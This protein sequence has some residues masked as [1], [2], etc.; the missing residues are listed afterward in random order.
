KPISSRLES[1]ETVGKATSSARISFV[2]SS[3]G[4]LIDRAASVLDQ[5]LARISAQAFGRTILL[6][7]DAFGDFEAPVGH[8]QTRH[9]VE[10]H[11]RLKHRVVFLA[12]RDGTLAP[13]RRI[14]NTDRIAAAPV[15]A[16]AGA[17]QRRVERFGDMACRVA[18]AGSLQARLD[19]VDERTFSIAHILW[20]VAQKD[21]PA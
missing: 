18:G 12:Q 1:A 17:L 13:I 2:F 7:E 5:K 21:G 15:A 8:P 4:V 6:D 11:V 3:S 9:E 20:R 14:G 10:C 16:D 19:T